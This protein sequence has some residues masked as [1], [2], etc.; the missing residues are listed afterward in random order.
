[1]GT[2]ALFDF[3]TDLSLKDENVDEYLEKI[4]EQLGQERTAEE[5]AEEAVKELVF[6]QVIFYL[7]PLPPCFFLI[8]LGI[9]IL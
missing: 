4:Q 6:Q 1:M 7:S 2:R 8:F 3:V 9:I 5:E